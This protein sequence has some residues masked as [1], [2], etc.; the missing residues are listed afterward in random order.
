MHA[1]GKFLRLL[2]VW[3]FTL[4]PDHIRIRSVRNSA[5]DSAVASSLIAVE[6]FPG[7]GGVPV[8]VDVH[9]CESFGNGPGLGIT[10]SFDRGE[11][12]FDEA[13]LIHVNTCVDH[14]DNCV[15]EEFEAR[16]SE[17]LIF[18]CLELVTIFA[19][20]FCGNHEVVERLE[21]RVRDAEN[22]GMISL[23]NGG[24]NEGSGF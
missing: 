2:K 14:F 15:V 22:E 5:I 17:P 3:Q 24:G 21:G 20:L 18:D 6:T 12:F 7:S 19:G 23:V 8:P 11:I 16:L 13:L 10:L 9:S 1:V 4:H